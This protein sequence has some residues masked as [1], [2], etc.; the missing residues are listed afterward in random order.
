M[1]AGTRGS[2]DFR[3]Q[4]LIPTSA[5]GACSYPS[6]VPTLLIT[7]EK[8]THISKPRNSWLLHT[9]NSLP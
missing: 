2:E 5:S 3:L 1:Q 8:M 6:P 9:A 7:V 4:V